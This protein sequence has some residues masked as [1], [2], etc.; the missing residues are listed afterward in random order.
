MKP[1]KGKELTKKVIS[2]HGAGDYS[3]GQDS[4]KLGSKQEIRT[5][6]S[7]E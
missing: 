3:D 7:A 4:L 6:K 1:E 2:K 5:E